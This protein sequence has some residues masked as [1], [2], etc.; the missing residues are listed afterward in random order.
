[1]TAALV[2][3]MLVLNV[4]ACLLAVRAIRTDNAIDDVRRVL[5]RPEHMDAYRAL[6]PQFPWDRWCVCSF[7]GKRCPNHPD[8]NE[9][10][11]DSAHRT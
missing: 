6:Q 3:A 2:A 8:E 1:M 5:G 7:D 9:T 4:V 10:Q 11:E